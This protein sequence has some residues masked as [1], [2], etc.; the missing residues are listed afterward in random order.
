MKRIDLVARNHRRRLAS[1]L[2]LSEGVSLDDV[3]AKIYSA[4]ERFW[5]KYEATGSRYNIELVSG[6][7]LLTPRRHKSKGR[8]KRSAI[9]QYVTELAM[10]YRDATGK[11]GRINLEVLDGDHPT[12]KAIHHPFLIACIEAAGL[13]KIKEDDMHY[14]SRIFQESCYREEG[15]G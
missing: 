8:P 15:L 13:G 12:Y 10:I 4:I 14:P 7:L 1:V 3:P 2:P 5:E 9:R 11:V 6:G